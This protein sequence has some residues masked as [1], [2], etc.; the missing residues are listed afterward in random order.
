MK[1]EFKKTHKFNTDFSTQANAFNC[2]NLYRKDIEEFHQAKIKPIR[3][4]RNLVAD[5]IVEYV[6]EECEQ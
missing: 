5:Y 2:F 1:F 3:M 4:Y 6:I